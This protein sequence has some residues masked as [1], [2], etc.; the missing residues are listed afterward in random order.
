MVN[1]TNNW[2]WNPSFEADTP[3]APPVGY[4]PLP[5]TTIETTTVDAN[6]GQQ[7]MLVQTVGNGTTEG[8]IGPS[9]EFPDSVA[10]SLSVA[11][12]GPTGTVM[13]SA[14]INPGGVT[15]GSQ[16]AYLTDVWQTVQ[17]NGL[18][19][20][21]GTSLQLVITTTSPEVLSFMVDCVQYEADDQFTSAY[22]AWLAN[23]SLPEPVPNPYIDGSL[24]GCYWSGAANSSAS[25]QPVQFAINPVGGVS[26]GGSITI[27]QP[28]TILS[29]FPDDTMLTGQISSGGQIYLPPSG[30][31]LLEPAGAFDDFALFELSTVNG[32]DPDP[33][34]TY[35]GW[36]N[37]G[38]LSA[39]TLPYTRS[40]GV[41]YPP[42]DYPCSDTDANGNPV[43]I[44]NRAAYMAMGNEFVGIL[45]TAGQNMTLMQAEMLPIVGSTLTPAAVGLDGTAT[46][47]TPPAPS[48]YDTPRSIHTIVKPTRLNYCPNPSFE[49]SLVNWTSSG[50]A[51]LVQDSTQVCWQD[52]NGNQVAYG[53][54]LYS[55]KVVSTT[56]ADG[57]VVTV[58][59]LFVGDTYTASIYVLTQSAGTGDIILTAGSSV[60]GVPGY[61]MEALVNGTVPAADL[62][63]SQW[64]RAQVTFVASAST[65]YLNVTPMASAL[66]TTS[67]SL[68]WNADCC[69]IEEGEIAG[70]YFDGNFGSP[71][72]QWEV[73]PVTGT[74][75]KIVPTVDNWT[76]ESGKGNWVSVEN[77][78][79]AASTTHAHGGQHS[80]RLTPTAAAAT[81]VMAAA[82]TATATQGM[83]VSSLTTTAISV[84][85]WFMSPFHGRNCQVGVTFYDSSHTKISTVVGNKVSDSSTWT[86]VS[87]SILV[88]IAAAWAV[89]Y[90][91]VVNPNE[92]HYVDTVT[93]TINKTVTSTTAT[94]VVDTNTSRSYYYENYAVNQEVITDVLTN[95]TP[96]GITP[97]IPIYDQAPT[98]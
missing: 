87:A 65:M 83:S 48:P 58:P 55:M 78:A 73:T 23:P 34:M 56:A 91:Q 96:L 93:M 21:G 62:P 9:V 37:A 50:L 16:V 41:F 6:S 67:W 79:I 20:M 80:L 90:V 1:F 92:I 15:L 98:Q 13:V 17:I 49:S 44:W 38:A 10:G 14:V 19:I 28:G 74:S 18:N 36:S 61:A 85:A 63:V 51:A 47:D 4:T 30:T 82:S 42:L 29:L 40:W 57:A 71:D 68:A 24:A 72:Y 5:N 25:Y 77:C 76:F 22:A 89:T 75:T 46:G 2:C 12:S 70:S 53:G 45:N 43:N 3:G 94:S 95:H 32:P 7:S 64:V 66:V 59:N 52:I 26:M 54:D 8:F 86:Q 39:Q 84:T 11:L 60:G 81:S 35:A 27:I 33:A 97:A 88:P 69:L 31:F